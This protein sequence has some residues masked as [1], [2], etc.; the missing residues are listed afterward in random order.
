LDLKLREK[1]AKLNLLRKMKRMKDGF[2]VEEEF[3]KVEEQVS[4]AYKERNEFKVI[5]IDWD[6]LGYGSTQSSSFESDEDG[7][8]CDCMVITKLHLHIIEL[9][10]FYVI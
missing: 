8:G 7:D 10:Y 9:Q 6:K 4:K 1:E 2:N 3:Q 5:S